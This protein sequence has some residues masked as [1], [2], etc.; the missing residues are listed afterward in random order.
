MHVFLIAPVNPGLMSPGGTRSYVLGLAQ[1]LKALGVDVTLLGSG[2]RQ[3][4]DFGEFVSLGEDLPKSNFT[5]LL[6]LL[7]WCRNHSDSLDGVVD[8]QRPDFLY[9]FV[10]YAR[11]A[12][13]VCTLHGDPRNAILRRRTPLYPIYTTLERRALRAA[14]HV[15]S[16]SNRGLQAYETRYPFLRGKASV[17][18]IGV[19]FGMF[20]PKE[21]LKARSKYGLDEDLTLLFAGRIAPEKRLH[22]VLDA[23]HRL[24]SPCRL[25]VAGNTR[26]AMARARHSWNLPVTY[27]G[28][29]PHEE[30][31]WL[32]S[33][34]DGLILASEYEGTPTVAVEALACGLP[35]LATPVGDLPEL[36][37]VGHT[38]FLFDGTAEAL[39]A[40]LQRVGP[41]L[42]S[43]RSECVESARPF[44]WERISRRLVEVF[45]AAE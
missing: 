15:V 33:A 45:H 1:A 22:V 20:S 26:P 44:A 14:H 10:R 16:V 29:I 38:G 30:M 39:A 21:R 23:L 34:A 17:I 27:L 28:V 43:M 3:D 42:G 31:P 13:L 12:M 8:A 4:V 35:V 9:P 11:G 5:F 18:P 19:D 41:R 37:V 32:L 24:P 6:S 7:R 36:I 2:P 40:L 25:M